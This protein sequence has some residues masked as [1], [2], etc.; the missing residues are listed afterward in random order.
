MLTDGDL[1][2]IQTRKERERRRARHAAETPEQREVRRARKREY[3]RRHYR[4]KREEKL[5]KAAAYREVNA[6]EISARYRERMTEQ[7]KAE[8]RARQRAA[9]AANREQV[10]A[11]KRVWHAA[12]P[13]YAR[14]ADRDRY[15][16]DGR[17]IRG[18]KK[19]ARRDRQDPSVEKT[20]GKCG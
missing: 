6:F 19:D 14:Q 20:T 17:R 5:S 3:D 15:A 7:K 9:Y 13:D 4:V 12:N 18:L 8:K 10:R 16:R 2:A 11:R 1:R